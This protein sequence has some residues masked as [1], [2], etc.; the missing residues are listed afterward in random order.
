MRL[1]FFTADVFT[2]TPFGGNPLAV[3][4]DASDLDSEGMQ[5]IAREFNL[6][7][8]AFVLPPADPRHAC[9]VRIFTP[10][11][12]LPFAGHP[13]V[14]TALVLASTGAVPMDGDLTR[15]CFEEGVGP[16][17]VEIQA[18]DGVPRS[19]W[20]RVAQLPESGPPAPPPG[21]LAQVLSLPL[22]A[23]VTDPRGAEAYSCG[24]PFLFVPVRDRDALARARL[25]HGAWRLHLSGYW[26]PEVFVFCTAGAEEGA[27]VAARMFAPRLGIEEDPATGAAVAALA[28]YLGRDPDDGTLNW[29][30]SQGVDM[31]RPSILRLEAHRHEG[32][33][34]RV[35]VGGEAVIMSE[36]TLILPDA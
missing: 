29:T 34:R 16:V 36:G 15:V 11:T 32:A 21:H 20:L 10:A 35:R 17:E 14:G 26:A 2:D 28:G 22:E 31:G 9:R 5:R 27:D 13:T 1:H 6:S 8:T 4:P 7:E 3:L 30:V 33:L 19:A 24:V 12:E 25:D 23:L 18:R